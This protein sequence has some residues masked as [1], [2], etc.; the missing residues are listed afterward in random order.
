MVNFIKYVL[1]LTIL[2]ASSFAAADSVPP[3]APRSPS[4]IVA[5]VNAQVVFSPPYSSDAACYSAVGKIID[6]LCGTNAKCTDIKSKSIFCTP[7]D[8]LFN[9]PLSASQ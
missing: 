6:A 7:L 9:Q 5:L 2:L 1:C 8:E 3:P 4:V